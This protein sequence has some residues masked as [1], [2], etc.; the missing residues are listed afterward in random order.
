[1]VALRL[2]GLSSDLF[3]QIGVVVLI[4]LASKN[5]ILIVEFA[6]D[7]HARGASVEE[8]RQR[9]ALAPKPSSGRR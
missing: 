4:A 7:Q 1:M 2:S 6:M 8:A 3:A 9:G 5:A